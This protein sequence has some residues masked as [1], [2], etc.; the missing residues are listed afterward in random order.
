MDITR[1]KVHIHHKIHPILR[2]RPSLLV[3]AAVECASLLTVL[4]FAPEK[5]VLLFQVGFLR[6]QTQFKRSVM[7]KNKNF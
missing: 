7:G 4:R 5:L 2:G 3:L 1:G 6:G